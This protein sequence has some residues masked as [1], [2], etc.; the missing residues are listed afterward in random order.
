MVLYELVAG[1]AGPL[2]RR[3]EALLLL[4]LLIVDSVSLSSSYNR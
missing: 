1:D 2:A 3:E 4:A